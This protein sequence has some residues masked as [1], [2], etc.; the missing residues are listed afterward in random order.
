MSNGRRE[1]SGRDW[2]TL[3]ELEP[4]ANY[5]AVRLANQDTSMKKVQ[6]ISNVLQYHCIRRGQEGLRVEFGLL[7]GWLTRSETDFKDSEAFDVLCAILTQYADRFETLDDDV[8][9]RA[10]YRS[11]SDWLAVLTWKFKAFSAKDKNTQIEKKL[12]RDVQGYAAHVQ[13][14]TTAVEALADLST[15]ASLA[16]QCR[17]IGELLRDETSELSYQ[18][19]LAVGLTP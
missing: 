13:Q 1:A 3:A 16:D 18:A 2:P 12:I 19:R 7:G 9:R 8:A 6:D 4:V 14:T 10:L 5:I 17:R 15:G 11:L